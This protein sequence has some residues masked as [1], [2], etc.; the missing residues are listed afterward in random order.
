MW[1][2]VE[3]GEGGGEGWVLGWGRRKRQKTV[4][5]KQFKKIKNGKKLNNQPTY[6]QIFVPFDGV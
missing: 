2:G 6:E 5:E 4:L 1:R 3:I